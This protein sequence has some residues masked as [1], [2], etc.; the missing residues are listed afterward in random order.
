MATNFAG[1]GSGLDLNTIISQLVQVERQP[2]ARMKSRQ[3]LVRRQL[4]AL[5]G[6]SS[7]VATLA[8]ASS[9]L[10]SASRWGGVK[11]TS[12]D[13]SVATVASS[14]A[15][16]SGSLAFT[17]SN[18]ASAHSIRSTA[19]LPSTSDT[20]TSASRLILGTGLAA[21]GIASLRTNDAVATGSTAFSVSRASA[22]A[23]RSGGAPLQGL[24]T[25]DPT[26]DTFFVDISGVPRSITL[27]HGTYDRS[28]LAAALNA[29]FTTAG[30]PATASVGEDLALKLTT[31][32]EGSS[33]SIQV[34]G[35]TALAALG[36]SVDA[37][38]TSGTDALVSFGGVETTVSAAMAGSSVTLGGPGGSSVT[39]TLSG[40]LRVHSATVAV[41]DTGAKSLRSVVDAMNASRNISGVAAAAVR[42]GTNAYRLQ[43]SATRT[44]ASETLNVDTSALSA[45][46]SF[47]Q[48]SQ[49]ADAIITIGDG[50]GAYTVESS[51][52]TFSDLLPGVSVTVQKTGTTTVTATPDTRI[53]E[54]SDFVQKAN[55]ALSYVADQTRSGSA[56]AGVLAG[57]STVRSFATTLRR[58]IIGAA[59]SSIGI[60]V[61]RNGVITFNQEAYKAAYD[62]NPDGVRNAFANTATGPTGVSLSQASDSTLAG[63]YTLSISQSAT[64]AT[65]NIASWG[66]PLSFTQSSTTASYTPT[67]TATASEVAAGLN[68]SFTTAKLGLEA[69]VDG[70]AVLVRSTAWGTLGTFS[71]TEGGST[72]TAT[73]QNVAGSIAGVAATGLGQVLSLAPTVSSPAAGLRLLVE[74]SS[75]GALGNVAY[76]TGVAGRVRQLGRD[77]QDS[78]SVLYSARTSREARVKSFDTQMA[79]M[80]KRV[81]AK[82]EQLRR[83]YSA[84]DSTIGRLQNV[85]SW[86]A[87]QTNSMQANN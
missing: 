74:G 24:V 76:A 33:A 22:P 9:A 44:G 67:A 46:G 87:Q 38:A 60:S 84:M 1:L 80:E 23:V 65:V 40:G 6:V 49:A 50:A 79:A 2:I 27:A 32:L 11:A 72:T 78:M 81:K 39:A 82:E 13:T 43:L 64:R 12:S 58:S 5:E 3:D 17:V 36:L 35:G 16:S 51:S 26:N 14:S 52:N 68:S 53:E 57:D 28:A 70:A 21:A 85:S 45:L 59:S 37:T 8:T 48:S 75:T 41:V 61:D 71:F 83:Q 73:G 55:A 62:S 25:I 66:T 31:A 19:T 7:R 10:A 54:V 30:V 18:L 29:A 77:S 34:T 20:V 86:L 69:V 42:V 56:G 63:S 4:S 15:G 47:A